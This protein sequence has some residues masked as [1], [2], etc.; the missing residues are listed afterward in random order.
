M[1]SCCATQEETVTGGSDEQV[2]DL[3]ERYNSHR[4]LRVWKPGDGLTCSFASR[5]SRN[6]PCGPPVAVRHVVS[7][8]T[9]IRPRQHREVICAY[10]LSDQCSPGGL[11]LEA[12][13]AAREKVIVAHWD[14]YQTAVREFMAP[15][16]EAMIGN[17]PEELKLLVLDALA[18]YDRV[19]DEQAAT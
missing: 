11:S 4:E 13:T 8:P 7:H 1:P 6:R 18:R 2:I 12:E 17:L 5:A 10:H 9:S 19:T 16:V 3:G 14:E 15:L